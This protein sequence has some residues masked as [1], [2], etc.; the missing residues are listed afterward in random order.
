MRVAV[1]AVLAGLVLAAPA[2]AAP[3]TS[4]GVRL[5]ASIPERGVISARAVG[6]Y[7]YVSSLTG[8]SVFDIA[9]PQAP[10]RVGR[11]DLPNAQNEDVDVGSGIML[12]SDDPYGGRGVLHVIDIRDPAH[13]RELSTYRTWAPGIFSGVPR[14]GGIGHTATCIQ[15]C[16]YAWLAGS[17]AGIDV[18]DLRDPAHPRRAGRFAAKPAAGIFGTHDV[19]VDSS[20]L[21]WIAGSNGTAAYDPSRNPV[22]PRLVMRTDRR[23]SRGPL[24]DFI[25][26]NSQRLSRRV[27]AITEEDFGDQCRRAGTLQTWRIPRRGRLRPLDSFGVERDGKARVVCSAHYFDARAGLIA[28]GFYEQGVRL[29]DARRPGRLRQV[30]YYLSRPG[31]FWGALFAPTDT[32][33]ETVYG[34]DH[35]RGIDVLAIDRAALKPIRRRGAARP[36]ARPKYGFVMGIFGA[37]ERLR[38]GRR[39]SLDLVVNG[40]GGPVQVEATLSPALVDVQVPRGATWDPATRTL[41][42]TLAR[43][44]GDAMRRLRARVAPAAALGT[45]IEVVGYATGPDDPLP[46]DDRGVFRAVVTRRGSAGGA[47]AAAASSWRGFCLLPYDYT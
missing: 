37:P 7:L 28:Q 21:A 20:G 9:Q 3:E 6:H 41:R 26:H 38:R 23:G 14:R 19:Q 40:R 17:S 15:R 45:Q 35:S 2:Q 27:V 31:L 43:L 46:L 36:L 4:P 11:L 13:P 39:V 32:A 5:I 16:R 25:H 12:V 42:Y 24:N 18:V 30:G 34:I 22:H 47:R 29:I 1:I 10:V 33:G 44:R 8:V